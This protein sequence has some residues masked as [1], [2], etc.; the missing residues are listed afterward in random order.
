LA[1]LE[2]T[3]KARTTAGPSTCV[4][5]KSASSCAQDDRVLFALDFFE[6]KAKAKAKADPPPSAKDDN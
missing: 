4:A 3:T 6:A 2:A 5:R 1:Y